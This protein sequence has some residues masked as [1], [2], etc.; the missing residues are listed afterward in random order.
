ML[1]SFYLF[2]FL[3]DILPYVETVSAVRVWIC[4]MRGWWHVFWH[5]N[6]QSR[7]LLC[8]YPHNYAITMVKDPLD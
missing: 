2:D 8:M 3:V 4:I 5:F 7:S 1:P 6:L